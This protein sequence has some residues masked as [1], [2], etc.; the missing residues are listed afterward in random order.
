MK[1]EGA[2]GTGAHGVTGRGAGQALVGRNLTAPGP[3]PQLQEVAAGGPGRGHSISVLPLS[4]AC[5]SIITTKEEVC[6]LRKL[7]TARFCLLDVLEK[8]KLKERK[9]DQ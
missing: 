5:E 6:C 4:T 8:A 3:T 2:G 7:H 1:G 9:T